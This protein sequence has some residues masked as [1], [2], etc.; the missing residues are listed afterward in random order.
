M[1]VAAGSGLAAISEECVE[2]ESAVTNGGNATD[3][4]L[5]LPTNSALEPRFVVLSAPGLRGCVPCLVPMAGPG[6]AAPVL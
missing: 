5:V 3:P 4:K 2:V 6:V 1:F